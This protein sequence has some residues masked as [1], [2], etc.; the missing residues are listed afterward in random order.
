MFLEQNRHSTQSLLEKLAWGS[1][2]HSWGLLV[3]KSSQ[4]D[5]WLRSKNR[6]VLPREV[7]PQPGSCEGKETETWGL[8]NNKDHRSPTWGQLSA[9]ACATRDGPDPEKPANQTKLERP[10]L[11][12]GILSLSRN[13]YSL[14]VFRCWPGSRVSSL[15]LPFY[16]HSVNPVVHCWPLSCSPRLRW[17]FGSPWF[18]FVCLFL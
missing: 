10:V 3:S 7:L 12:H 5:E 18:S 16:I 15:P 17:D 14:P 4:W 1:H 8:V 2:P 13:T 6:G 9:W 11:S